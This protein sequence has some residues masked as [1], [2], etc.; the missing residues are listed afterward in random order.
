MDLVQNFR[1]VRTNRLY[2]CVWGSSSQPSMFS[3]LVHIRGFKTNM[4]KG[5]GITYYYV[6]RMRSYS[7]YT[8]RFVGR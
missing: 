1:H 7:V 6:K 4:F 2:L 8:D 5:L 3:R